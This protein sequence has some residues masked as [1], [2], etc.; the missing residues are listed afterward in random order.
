MGEL[1]WVLSMTIVAVAIVGAVCNALVRNT[2]AAIVLSICCSFA[3]WW[4]LAARNDP[5]WPI[6]AFIFVPIIV[7]VSVSMGMLGRASR[8]AIDAA[9]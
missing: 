9:D 6:A 1:G 4:Y 2:I 3:L 5:F 7:V 8:R